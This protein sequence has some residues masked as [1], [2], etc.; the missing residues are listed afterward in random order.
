[1]STNVSNT[2][3]AQVPTVRS[4][5]QQS[6][7]QNPPTQQHQNP[8]MATPSQVQ[9]PLGMCRVFTHPKSEK[10]WTTKLYYSLYSGVYT[11]P[12]SQFLNTLIL[13]CNMS[14]VGNLALTLL[15]AY[16]LNCTVNITTTLKPG[17]LRV[18]KPL[19]N[20]VAAY[21][22]LIAD[23]IGM[24]SDVPTIQATHS[25]NPQACLRDLLNRW[26]NQGQ[27]TLEALCQALRDD[28][29]IIGGAGVAAKL[30]EEF[31]RRR[32]FWT[33]N[34]KAAKV[35]HNTYTVELCCHIYNWFCTLVSCLHIAIA[36][37]MQSYIEPCC[38]ENDWI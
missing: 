12:F 4:P 35:R 38:S 16:F 9:Q 6:K 7:Y 19:L 29:E 24:G 15:Y 37:S 34:Y 14:T 13:S 22:V 32:G 23:Q 2:A 3:R 26:L 11:W 10:C 27:P 8:Q 1:M 21:W 30:K 33:E 5:D 18:L 36:I 20:P 28:P 25:N 17:D 31:Q